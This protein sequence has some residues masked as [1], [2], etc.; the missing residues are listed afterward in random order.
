VTSGERDA[1]EPTGA[2]SGPCRLKPFPAELSLSS[3]RRLHAAPPR[4]ARVAGRV[5]EP[6]QQIAVAWQRRA[7]ADEIATAQLVERAQELVLVG[8]PAL[9]FCDDGAAI[10][11][12]ANP[13]RIDGVDGPRSSPR[14]R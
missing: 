12:G 11:V 14:L 4:D 2:L 8:E 1:G 13:E 6:K 9:V 3:R 5:R 10:T 7:E